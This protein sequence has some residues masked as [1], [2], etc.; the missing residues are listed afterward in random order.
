MKCF[1]LILILFSILP[2]W[3][4]VGINTNT[5]SATLDVQGS[6]LIDESL[7]LE[8]PGNSYEIRGSKFLIKTT[9][10]EILEYDIAA[11]KYGPINTAQFVFRNTSTNGLQDYDTKISIN[12]YIVTVQGYYFTAQGSTN[13]LLHSNLADE[14]IEGYQIYA[15]PNVVTNTWF[16]RAFVNDSTFRSGPGFTDNPI[17]LFLNLVIYRQRFIA[18][19]LTGINVNMNNSE[20][21]NAPL[22]VGF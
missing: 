3:A 4:Q 21:G 19:T 20:T 11:S 16:L 22:P 1:S 7:Y 13:V 5:P 14:N 2:L 6:T 15:Y 17:D 10:N 12:D 8:A 18:K 9:A